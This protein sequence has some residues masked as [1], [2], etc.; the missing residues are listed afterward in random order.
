VDKGLHSETLE[1]RFSK[2]TCFHAWR[3]QAKNTPFFFI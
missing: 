1:Q 2:T 3:A